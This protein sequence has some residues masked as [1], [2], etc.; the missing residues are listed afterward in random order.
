[1]RRTALLFLTVACAA[2]GVYYYRLRTPGPSTQSFRTAAV[3]RGTLVPRIKA[4]GTIEPQ[5]V[6]DVGAQVMGR[7]RD[8]G[9]DHNAEETRGPMNAQASGRSN[10]ALVSVDIGQS[11]ANLC[12][13]D[14]SARSGQ[15]LTMDDDHYTGGVDRPR[16]D[17]NSIVHIGTELA[18][19]DA[20]RYEAQ[21]AQARAAV[22][23]AIADLE[24]LEAKAAQAAAELRRAE[25]LRSIQRTPNPGTQVPVVI[26]SESDYDMAVANDK[27]AKA[28][29]LIGKA[30]VEQN[31][32]ACD[33]ARTDLDFTVIKSPVEGV[34]LERRVNI[35]QTVVAALNAP[36]LFLIALDLSRLQ[37]W[38]SVNE[39]DIGRIRKGMNV[40][41]TVDAY[42][43]FV[44]RLRKADSIECAD[45]TKRG[46]VYGCRRH[47][48]SRW[49]A[50]ALH[51]GQYAVRG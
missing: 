31:R 26:I 46:H 44:C 13:D 19:I 34:I 47:G 40:T 14:T 43:R 6:V 51:D 42:P 33:L 20:T 16:I 24:Q 9:V 18:Y 29:L 28:N 7:I 48:E 30:V 8:L 37:V 27:V 32:A 1:M 10:C 3:Q 17:Y 50:T 22:Q 35:G 21:Y 11:V 23:K 2:G 12:S 15:S 4:T 5:D 38:A 49:E 39:A 36:S 25:K 45:D 41:F